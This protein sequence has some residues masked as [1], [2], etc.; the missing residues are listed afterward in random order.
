MNPYLL[1]QL[2]DTRIEDL[3]R[4]A[5]GHRTRAARRRPAGLRRR[6]GWTLIHLGLRLAAAGSAD[7]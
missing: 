2:A 7:A 3:R 4:S 5:D 1:G 6:A